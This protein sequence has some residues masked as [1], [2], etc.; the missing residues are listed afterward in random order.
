MPSL[1]INTVWERALN[2]YGLFTALAKTAAA[3]GHRVSIPR[4]YNIDY[5]LISK[6][7]E[8]LAIRS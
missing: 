8:E 7:T 2:D 1:T 3:R 6:L 5:S 4:P